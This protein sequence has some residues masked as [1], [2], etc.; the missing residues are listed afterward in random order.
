MAAPTS[1]AALRS[2]RNVD[3]QVPART[4]HRSTNFR[5]PINPEIMDP[6]ACKYRN[7]ASRTEMNR[8]HGF[9]LFSFFLTA[10][11]KE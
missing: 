9:D 3:R 10:I 5:F 4:A 7:G 6:F 8:N 1:D 2:I 11:Y